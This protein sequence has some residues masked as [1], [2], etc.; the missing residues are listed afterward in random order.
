MYSAVTYWKIPPEAHQDIE[1]L[2][3][4]HACLFKNVESLYVSL[5]MSNTFP[6]LDGLSLEFVWVLLMVQDLKMNICK[7]AIANFLE[8]DKLDRAVGGKQNSL[9]EIEDKLDL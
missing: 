7:W 4:N 9:G 8:F 1:S 2:K 5:N 6:E 3:G